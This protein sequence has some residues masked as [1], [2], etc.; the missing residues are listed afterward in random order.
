[1]ATKPA[2]LILG[3]YFEGPLGP[4]QHSVK[5]PL[6]PENITGIKVVLVFSGER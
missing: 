3:G 5:V 1:M 6:P 2:D 4:E